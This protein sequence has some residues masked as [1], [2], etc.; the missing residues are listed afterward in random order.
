MGTV[1]VGEVDH[2]LAGHRADV[3]EQFVG[4]GDIVWRQEHVFQSTETVGARDGL[5]GETIQGGIAFMPAS[6]Q[7]PRQSIQHPVD[8]GDAVWRKTDGHL[9]DGARLRLVEQPDGDRCGEPTK[10]DRPGFAGQVGDQH[11]HAASLP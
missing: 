7:S 10:G 1:A 6:L 5:I 3:A 11:A 9:R 8:P 4:P 2:A